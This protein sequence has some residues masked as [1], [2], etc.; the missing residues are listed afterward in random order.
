MKNKILEGL[1]AKD[2]KDLVLPLISV[3]E[4]ESR[5]SEK[6]IV[7]GFLVHDKDAADDLNRFIQKSA[8]NV[9]DTDVSPAP[10]QHGYYFV[11]IEIMNDAKF[12]KAVDSLIHEVSPLVDVHSWKMRIRKTKSLLAYTESNLIKGIE[13]ANRLKENKIYEFF[14]DSCLNGLVIEETKITM[15][16]GIIFELCD[17]GN[18]DDILIEND[19]AD[20]PF[21]VTFKEAVHTNKLTKML[22]EG[23]VVNTINDNILLQNTNTDDALLLIK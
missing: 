8:I 1:R 4:Y 11:F 22:G 3:D 13:R 16:H 10:D 6:A 17:F 19:L 21:S 2:L 9:L 12:S 18:V 14:K 7:I 15:N 20:K 5:I 23:W